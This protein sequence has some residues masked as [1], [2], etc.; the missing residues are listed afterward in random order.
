MERRRWYDGTS[1]PLDQQKIRHGEHVKNRT[2][3]RRPLCE[4]VTQ[5]IETVEESEDP[6]DILIK[7]EDADEASGC[8]CGAHLEEYYDRFNPIITTTKGNKP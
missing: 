1:D 8:S 6:V 2:D 5:A 7:C 3:P 4:Q